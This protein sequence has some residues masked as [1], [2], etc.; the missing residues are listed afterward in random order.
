[1]G[2]LV[3]NPE[4]GAK[5]GEVVGD[6][7]IG[8]E[9][10]PVKEVGQVKN[11]TAIIKIRS[12]VKELKD[13]VLRKGLE[14]TKKR[15]LDSLVD[16]TRNWILN[17]GQPRFIRDFKGFLGDNL[18]AAVGDVIVDVGAAN[19]CLPQQRQFLNQAL[20]TADKTVLPRFS[21]RISCTI[22]DVTKN[23]EA[24]YRDFRNGGFSAY[25]ALLEPQNNKYGQLVMVLD[26]IQQRK[27][28]SEE[29]AKLEATAN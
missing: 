6:G 12:C 2:G 24:F 18:S 26:E 7:L 17:G 8:E 1:M 3:G 21:E 4:G 23:V 16:D 29:A 25:Q 20:G 27:A 11:D 28:E 5:A 13:V 10:K 9:P 22:G 15:L 14:R 19:L